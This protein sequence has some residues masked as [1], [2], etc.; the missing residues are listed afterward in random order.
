MREG[1]RGGATSGSRRLS[2]GFVVVQLALALLLLIGAGLLLRSFQRTLAVDPG[3]RPENVLTARIQ[4][5]WPAYANDTVVRVFHRRLIEA[6]ASLP[7]VARVGL[8]SRPPFSP[9]NPQQNLFVEH[10][11]PPSA[12]AVPVV[13]QRA[14]S[15]GYFEAIGTPLLSGRGFLPSDAAGAPPVV[16]VDETVAREYWPAGSALGKRIKTSTDSGAPWLTIVGVVKNVKHSSLRERPNFEIYQPL[17]QSPRWAVYVVARTSGA[18][19]P[20]VAGLRR[21]VAEM[22]PALPIS[23]VESLDEAMDRSLGVVRVTNGLLSGFAALALLLAAIGIYGVMA[24]NV[25]GRQ[26]EFGVRLALGATPREV[27]VLVMR[28]GLLLAALG[29]LLG[30]LGAVALTRLLGALLFEV[31]P[32][33]PGTFAAVGLILGAAAVAACYVPARRATRADPMAVLRRE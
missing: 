21:I 32:L 22:D 25:T 27:L 17:E 2:H 20:V 10:Q 1:S 9:G 19:D 7:G 23:H 30:L 24:L 29:L 26:G 33:D 12:N 18:P 3:F 6:A 14:A 15:T 16:V 5:P 4:L 8:V 13:N 11:P 28:Q 31:S